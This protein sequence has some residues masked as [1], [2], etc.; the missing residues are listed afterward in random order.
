MRRWPGFSFNYYIE[1]QTPFIFIDSMSVLDTPRL[2]LRPFRANDLDRLAEL[3]ANP[4]FM[5]FSSGVW[6]REQTAV[7]LDKAIGWERDGLP[8][9]F[10]V[11]IKP[12]KRVVGYCGFLHHSQ[13]PGEIEIGYLLDPEYWNRGVITEAARAVRDHAFRALN[14]ARVVSLIH[15][16]NVPSRRVA[17]KNGLTLEKQITFRG[18]PTNLFS[19]SRDR[20]LA[21]SGA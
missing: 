7:L 18:F 21:L 19:L 12:E 4:G 11:E 16:D 3:F 10:A 14:L 9:L 6:G 13:L 1:N 5:R 8:S 15:P 2:I 20:W 17:E